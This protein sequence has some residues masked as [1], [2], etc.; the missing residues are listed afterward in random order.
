M[1]IFKQTRVKGAETE[2]EPIIHEDSK[3]AL[4]ARGLERNKPFD[5]KPKK[6][7]RQMQRVPSMGT[8]PVVGIAIHALLKSLAIKPRAGSSIIIC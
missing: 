4:V 8:A 7:L 3:E 2:H 1:G 6:E 5:I